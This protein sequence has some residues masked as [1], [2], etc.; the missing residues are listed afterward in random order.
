M[1]GCFATEAIRAWGDDGQIDDEQGEWQGCQRALGARN[2]WGF[3]WRLPRLGCAVSKKAKTDGGEVVE[4]PF[5][6]TQLVHEGE[7][8]EEAWVRGYHFLE[9]HD[10]RKKCGAYLRKDFCKRLPH[11]NEEGVIY[12]DTTWKDEIQYTLFDPYI[13][14]SLIPN[15]VHGRG[16]YFL[17]GIVVKKDWKYAIEPVDSTTTIDELL[18]ELSGE[19]PPPIISPAPASGLVPREASFPQV[20][21]DA[22]F[23][24]GRVFHVGGKAGG[25]LW[26]AELR[27]GTA[28][29]LR[30]RPGADG[31][32]PC[33]DLPKFSALP[34]APP[35]LDVGAIDRTDLSWGKYGRREVIIDLRNER[36]LSLEDLKGAKPVPVVTGEMAYPFATEMSVL[37][38]ELVR[39]EDGELVAIQET[40]TFDEIHEA[41]IKHVRRTSCE[42]ADHVRRLIGHQLYVQLVP[43]KQKNLAD[44]RA[45]IPGF[46]L[47]SAL[48][49][50]PA[51]QWSGHR[52]L[53]LELFFESLEQMGE[54]LG[55][56]VARGWAVA[57]PPPDRHGRPVK[58]S[59]KTENV[60]FLQPFTHADIDDTG[61]N[62]MC[63]SMET[64]SLEV[65][66]ALGIFGNNLRYRRGAT[67]PDPEPDAEPG[68]RYD[69]V[70]RS[71]RPA[72]ATAEEFPPLTLLR[73]E[74]A[75]L[76]M[77]Y[78]LS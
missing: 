77:P 75:L 33:L 36:T 37:V 22:F 14:V 61:A 25:V 40:L 4:Q 31:L 45:V 3:W 76:P 66:L 73:A 49:I 39:D 70:T 51:L 35:E 62:W 13:N 1:Y 29:V 43:E 44:A 64:K 16:R 58:R 12:L 67:P 38:A 42:D 54:I 65:S 9:P 55:E 48:A 68:S 52:R 71:Y 6:A 57:P 46:S 20:E 30:T 56:F 15:A 26:A 27:D 74:N 28:V 50:C 41:L 78:V 18:S 47:G 7:S 8:P 11:E 63:L 34:D 5:L 19:L 21:D 69:I 17:G 10:V 53:N 72:T 32:L 2:A 59:R 60:G 24:D 23:Y